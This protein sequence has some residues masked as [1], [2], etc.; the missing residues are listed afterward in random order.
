MKGIIPTFHDKLNRRYKFILKIGRIRRNNLVTEMFSIC[1]F[2]LTA[3]H[4]VCNEYFACKPSPLNTEDGLVIDYDPLG[5]IM[6]HVGLTGIYK[7]VLKNQNTYQVSN[8]FILC[9][10]ETIL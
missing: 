4:C 6:I 9:I 3:A 8:I 1:R 10:I 5:K 7:K 2:I